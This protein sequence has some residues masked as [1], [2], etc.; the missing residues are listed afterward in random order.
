MPSSSIDW[1]NTQLITFT[2][3]YTYSMFL[4]IQYSSIKCTSLQSFLSISHFL[5]N[6]IYAIYHTYRNTIFMLV[7]EKITK[8]MYVSFP[9]FSCTNFRN[10]YAQI[11]KFNIYLCWNVAFGLT[12]ITKLQEFTQS[13]RDVWLIKRY[14]V[15]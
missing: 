3:I 7:F 5:K 10:I 9:I 15:F 1:Y 4:P 12:R 14:V 2:V 6:I 13:F 8:L 11:S